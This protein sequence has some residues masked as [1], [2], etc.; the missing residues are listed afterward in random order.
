MS[1]VF[2][3]RA[4]TSGFRSTTRGLLAWSV[5]VAVA[6][7]TLR[8]LEALDWS[9]AGL[10]LSLLAAGF[11]IPAAVIFQVARELARRRSL[12]RIAT[13]LVLGALAW[14]VAAY[15]AYRCLMIEGSRW[16]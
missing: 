6:L 8:V 9:L 13:V 15:S 14:V 12:A 7:A 1:G 16:G 2:W 4:V 5:L 3:L 10:N 11:F